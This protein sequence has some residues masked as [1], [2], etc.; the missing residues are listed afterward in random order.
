M[1]G[2]IAAGNQKANRAFVGN[3]NGVVFDLFWRLIPENVLV[4]VGVYF[5]LTKAE[6]EFFSHLPKRIDIESV[7]FEGSLGDN[8]KIFLH[9]APIQH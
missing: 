6:S 7:Q 9:L 4:G 2:F 8:L 1:A 3:S 5:F